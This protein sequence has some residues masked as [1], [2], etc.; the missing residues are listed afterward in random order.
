MSGDSDP[1]EQ[2][3][4]LLLPGSALLGTVSSGVLHT[5]V[6]GPPYCSACFCRT[7]IL[8]TTPSPLLCAAEQQILCWSTERVNCDSS[9]K[10]ES[11]ARGRNLPQASPGYFPGQAP[12]SPL[13]TRPLRHA[14][15]SVQLPVKLCLL[16]YPTGFGFRETGLSFQVSRVILKSPHFSSDYYCTEDNN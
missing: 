9:G 10:P 12:S 1:G 6:P 2:G 3:Q 13:S 15:G 14:T 4:N 7:E 11:G 8:V 5:G 16:S